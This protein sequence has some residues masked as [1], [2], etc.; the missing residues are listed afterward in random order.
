MTRDRGKEPMN[1]DEMQN[2]QKEL[3]EK[4]LE[5][6]G[7]LSLEIG[8]DLLLWMIGEAGEVADIIKKNGDASILEDEKIHQDFV[9]EMCD[10]LM[11]FNDIMLCYSISPEELVE[12]YRKKHEKNMSRW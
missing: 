5:K 6:W 2:M 12:M 10:V 1:F 4:Y 7:P 11:Y 8:R 9:E 3:H